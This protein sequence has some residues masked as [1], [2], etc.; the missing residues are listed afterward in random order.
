MSHSGRWVVVSTYRSRL[1]GEDVERVDPMLDHA[2]LGRFALPSDE[3][4]ALRK[5]ARRGTG[6]AV[7]R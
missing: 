3:L 6:G 4:R 7:L 5:S 1:V 2:T